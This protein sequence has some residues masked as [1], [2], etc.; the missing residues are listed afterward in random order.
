M[1]AA[2]GETEGLRPVVAWAVLAA[3]IVLVTAVILLSAQTKLYRRVPLEMPPE[4][5]AQ[6]ARDI[7]QSAG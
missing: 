2:S 3:V 4:A 5:L 7:L 1:V 6:R